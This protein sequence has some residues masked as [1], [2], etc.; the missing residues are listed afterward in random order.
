MAKF[1]KTVSGHYTVQQQKERHLANDY[2]KQYDKIDVSAPEWLDDT[3]KSIFTDT[4]E[5]SRESTLKQLDLPL[6]ATY[7]Q[8]YAT[9]IEVSEKLQKQGITLKDGRVNPLFRVFNMQTKNLKEL[10]TE[11]GISPSAR[12]RIEYNRAKNHR[13]DNK[14]DPFLKVVGSHKD[15]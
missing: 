14:P 7:A 11:L 4:I 9:I 8:T 2:L 15:D 5:A 1:K 3:A 12:A 13:N 6:L 10:S